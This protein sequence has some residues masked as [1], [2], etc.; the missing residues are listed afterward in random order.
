MPTPVLAGSGFTDALH[1]GV[2]TVFALDAAIVLVAA[3]L[4][5]L[6]LRKRT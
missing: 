2:R 3:L 5:A 4:L 1:D 6:G